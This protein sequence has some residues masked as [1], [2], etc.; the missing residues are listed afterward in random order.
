MIKN[1]KWK[2][3]SF[4]EV[5]LKI[6]RGK[7]LIREKQNKG[8]MPYVSSSAL[9]NGID[10]FIDNKEG[11]RIFENCISLANSGSVGSAFFHSYKF[12]ASDHV[13][14]LAHPSFNKYIYLFFLPVIARLSEKYGFN[15]E[16]NDRRIKRE[17]L[18]LPV[19]SK[20]KINFNFIENYMK[21]LEENFIKKVIAYYLKKA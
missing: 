9:N 10:N 18:L 14:Q 6:K 16:I 21:K 8:K 20:G 2:E 3:F 15:R 12:I 5:F 13:T 4:G 17:K 11:V 19:D 1:I 7:R